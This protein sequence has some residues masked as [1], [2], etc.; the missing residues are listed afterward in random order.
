MT[1]RLMLSILVIQLLAAGVTMGLVYAVIALG[2]Q[3]VA[4]GTGIINFA[5]GELVVIGT[6][7]YFSLTVTY[8]VPPP[9]AVV[10]TVVAVIVV[11]VGIV[12]GIALAAIFLLLPWFP[13]NG[14]TQATLNLPPAN[15]QIKLRFVDGKTGRDL[16]PAYEQSLP[17]VGQERM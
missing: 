13:V 14:A 12:A 1:K 9:A 2:F 10:L 6:L 5:H 17:V 3:I 16:L 11:S 7:V 8:R 15:Y 4:R